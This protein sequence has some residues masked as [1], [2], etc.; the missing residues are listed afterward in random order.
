MLNHTMRPPAT[1]INAKKKNGFDRA[2]SN[3]KRRHANAAQQERDSRTGTVSGLAILPPHV[4]SQSICSKAEEL[5][6]MSC[7]QNR[8]VDLA[9]QAIVDRF[10]NGTRLNSLQT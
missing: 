5:K 1:C 4:R 7:T 8:S 9:A 3:H 10:F 2:V 6:Q